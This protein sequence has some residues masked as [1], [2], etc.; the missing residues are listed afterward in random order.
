MTLIW[1]Y[2]CNSL[3][4]FSNCSK[5]GAK[6]GLPGNMLQKPAM[7]VFHSLRH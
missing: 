6:I 2:H 3:Q 4:L 7:S 5:D 1:N